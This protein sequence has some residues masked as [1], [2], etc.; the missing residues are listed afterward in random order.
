MSLSPDAIANWV[1][2]SFAGVVPKQSYSGTSFFYNPGTVLPNGVYFLTMK[3]HDGPH[4]KASALSRPGVYRIS[5]QP[6]PESYRELFGERPARPAK[7]GV[8]RLPY[9][10]SRVN[11]LM[12]HPVYA[13]MGW[14][15]VLQPDTQ[16]F[17]ELKP[18]IEQSYQ[19]AVKKFQAKKRA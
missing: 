15:M 7:G 13:W 3:D 6:S 12:P 16:V 10:F 4:D 1:L 8:V 18:F 5:F 19:Q 17:E 2:A 11:V 14:V 9:D